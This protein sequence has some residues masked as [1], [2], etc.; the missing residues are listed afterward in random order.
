MS[1]LKLVNYLIIILI[2]AI[3]PA[4]SQEKMQIKVG[5]KKFTENV[6]LG[7][8][9]TQLAEYQNVNV[10]Y[11]R[12]LGGTRI[13]W[14]ALLKEEIDIYPEY[15]GTI[16]EEIFP[17]ENIKPE[18]LK[19]R[20]DEIGIGI[21]KPLGFNNTYAIGM[22]RENAERLGINKI[23]DLNNFPT[24][25][26]GFTNE[27]MDRHDGWPG[28]R[29]KY[30]LT[31]KEVKGLDHDLAYRGLEGGSIDVIDLYSTDAE[32]EYYNL[33]ILDDDLKY[34]TEYK[35]VIIYRKKLESLYPNFVNNIKEL[36]GVIS[37]SKMIKMNSDVKI[38][39]ESER[40]VAASFI[41]SRFSIKANFE[42]ISFIDRLWHNT[43][44]HLFLVII[45]LT[46]AILISIP[47]GIIAY[48]KKKIGKVILGFTGVIQTIPSLALLVFMIPLLGIGSWPA[49]SALFLYSLLPIVRNTFT[50]MEEIPASIRE[51][52]IVLGL[53]PS[54]I[55]KKIELPLASRS[56]LAGIKTSAVINVG[57]ATLGALIG[58]GGYGQ[59][60]L[61]GIRLDSVSLILEGA[62]PAAILALIVQWLFDF[63][64]KVIVPKGLRI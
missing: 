51:S 22:N 33:K 7:E 37:E 43:K 16:I 52:A 9:I 19:S 38:N 3:I 29:N 49:I 20:L 59:P 21:T 64:E 44:E 2:F 50:G 25:R 57:T 39:K 35:C 61:T 17:H 58:A 11:V 36:E 10:T 30:Q 42:E 14:N 6:I 45:S 13:L 15:T 46:G 56:I 63:S 48:K 28:L 47:L 24:M 31:Q 32:I 8:I 18:K 27:F 12:E 23:S 41:E 40:Q 5:S 4:L 54:A 53:S 26:F 55:L 1:E 34:F 62:V 60:I